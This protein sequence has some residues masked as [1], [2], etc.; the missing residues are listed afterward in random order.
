MSLPDYFLS[1][2]TRLAPYLFLILIP[3]RNH[4]RCSFRQSVLYAFLL[5]L[6]TTL[7]V[8]LLGETYGIDSIWMFRLP[9]SS[10]GSVSFWPITSCARRCA[11]SCF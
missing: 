4:L 9:V 2:G 5:Y 7:S 1:L 11:S 6:G 10:L 8:Y 3:F